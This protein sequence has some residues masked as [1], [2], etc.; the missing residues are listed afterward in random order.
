MSPGK[1]E[2]AMKLERLFPGDLVE[3]RH[4]KKSFRPWTLMRPWT[5]E[6]MVYI[7]QD[8]KLA[9]RALI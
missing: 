3:V 8:S 5:G 1:L 7:D 2:E 4:P 9:A 6:T